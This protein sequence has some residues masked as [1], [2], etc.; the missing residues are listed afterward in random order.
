[1]G[2]CFA[3]H[4][5]W[6]EKDQLQDAYDQAVSNALLCCGDTGYTGTIAES[7]GLTI[8]DEVEVFEYVEA[9]YG[10]LED[11]AEKWGDTMA[12][13]VEPLAG[14]PFWLFGGNYSS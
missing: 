6:A 7:T 11:N 9:A 5:V 1:M 12:V 13:R 4:Q 10:W 8:C 2:T 14:R 3:S